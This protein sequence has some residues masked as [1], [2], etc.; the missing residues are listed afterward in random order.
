[1]SNTIT[2]HGNASVN[3]TL[4]STKS[5]KPAFTFSVADTAR[6]QQGG[7]F[8]TWERLFPHTACRNR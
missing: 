2:I 5:G 3:Q 6:K 7:L 8:R 4:G 1:M